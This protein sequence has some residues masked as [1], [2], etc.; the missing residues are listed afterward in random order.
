[1]NERREKIQ[2]LHEELD[3]ICKLLNIEINNEYPELNKSIIINLNG[4]E[5]ILEDLSENKIN[6]YKEAILHAKNKLN[7]YKEKIIELKEEIKSF[8]EILS[9]SDEQKSKNPIDCFVNTEKIQIYSTKKQIDLSFGRTIELLEHR[10][11]ELLKIHQRLIGAVG[12]LMPKIV[13]LWNELEISNSDSHRMKL[14]FT[15]IKNKNPTEEEQ[16]N[17]LIKLKNTKNQRF[18]ISVIEAVCFLSFFYSYFSFV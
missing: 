17:F 4:E 5:K 9:F 8:W 15:L 13:H 11:D 12:D 14:W 2:N 18:P 10:R 6:K 3:P 1:M 7:E 16:N